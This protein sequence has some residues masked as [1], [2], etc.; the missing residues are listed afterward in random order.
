MTRPVSR[1][2]ISELA[3]LYGVRLHFEKTRKQHGEARYWINS[4]SVNLNQSGI[5]MLSTFFHEI[6]H[7]YCYQKGIWKSFHINK[8]L[9]DLTNSE[10]KKYI[11]TALKAER[12]VDRWAEKEMKKHFPRLKYMETY[13]S[14]EN[15]K[16]FSDSIKKMLNYEKR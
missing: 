1:K 2:I 15:G 8:P 5:S 11:A 7:V 12:W 3:L 16:N 10:R 6:G 13:L 14:E 9:E 4:I